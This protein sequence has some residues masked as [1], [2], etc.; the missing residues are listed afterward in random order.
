MWNEILN[1]A[2]PYFLLPSCSSSLLFPSCLLDHCAFL[3]LRVQA[4]H[5]TFTP[6][7]SI[8]PCY[9]SGF[10]LPPSINLS[11]HPP[12]LQQPTQRLIPQRERMR[13]EAFYSVFQLSPS[14]WSCSKTQLHQTKHH[15]HSPATYSIPPLFMAIFPSF[16]FV[17]RPLGGIMLR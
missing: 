2:P 5:S 9:S 8:L 11:M 12:S 14:L 6:S 17:F 16:L 13:G 4:A 3:P 10:P 15:P 1:A 7:L